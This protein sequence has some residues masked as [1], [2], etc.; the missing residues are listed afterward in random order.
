MK[1]RKVYEEKA[2]KIT[3][4]ELIAY[5]DAQSLINKYK[6]LLPQLAKKYQTQ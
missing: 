3:S 6:K 4:E 2:P 1:I 5:G